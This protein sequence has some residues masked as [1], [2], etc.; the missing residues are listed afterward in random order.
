MT[1][2]PLPHHLQLLGEGSYQQ[3]EE[4]AAAILRGVPCG[5]SHGLQVAQPARVSGLAS[6]T[7]CVEDVIDTS[8]C[9]AI[10]RYNFASVVNLAYAQRSPLALP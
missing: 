1:Q 10:S 3:L 9:C 7:Q 6:L 4:E 2:L 5:L 8:A